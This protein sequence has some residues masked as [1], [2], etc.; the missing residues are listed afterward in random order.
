MISNQNE[1]AAIESGTSHCCFETKQML[2]IS[3]L[4]TFTE[5]IKPTPRCQ[6]GHFWLVRGAAH[7]RPCSRVHCLTLG[8][9]SPASLEALGPG[10]TPDG[11]MSDRGAFDTNVV[12]LTR[13]V[14]EEGR[15]AHG[16]GELT[17]LLNSICTAVKAISTA[18]RK[19]GI[20][21][22]WVELL[23]FFEWWE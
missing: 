20:A 11:K 3:E 22:L 14:L 5:V 7:P 9:C 2:A 6:R 8:P 13:F 15:R 10:P 21:N 23:F 17:N 16:T 19:A 1:W 4:C 18:V 12:T